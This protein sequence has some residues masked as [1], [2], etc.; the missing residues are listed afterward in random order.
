M[1]TITLKLG[2]RFQQEIS[3][4]LYDKHNVFVGANGSGKTTVAL[5]LRDY[6]LEKY[7]SDEFFFFDAEKVMS[8]RAWLKSVLNKIQQSDPRWEEFLA[9]LKSG[10]SCDRR[11]DAAI[12]AKTSEK[13][14]EE[15]WSIFHGG[16]TSRKL[17]LLLCLFIAS[18]IF[19]KKITRDKVPLIF[20]NCFSMLDSENRKS[21]IELLKKSGRRYI[22]LNHPGDFDPNDLYPT[23]IIQVTVDRVISKWQEVVCGIPLV[24]LNGNLG[25][26]SVITLPPHQIKALP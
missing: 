18:N 11:L 8:Q 9:F 23:H 25:R 13:L 5:A 20:D 4:G 24:S 26:S 7:S 1:E 10:I 12:T 17:L 19:V 22:L 2:G 16:A 6:Y 15:V 3:L 21:I 14:C